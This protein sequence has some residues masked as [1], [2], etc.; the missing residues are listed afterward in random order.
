MNGINAVSVKDR[1]AAR[2]VA[3]L[4]LTDYS[5]TGIL[6]IRLKDEGKGMCGYWPSRWGV[7]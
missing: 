3:N 6:C 1:F 7:Y 4:G 5:Q 2:G